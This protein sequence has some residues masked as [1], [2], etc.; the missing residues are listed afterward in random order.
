MTFFPRGLGWT[1]AAM[2]LPVVVMFAQHTTKKKS[3]PPPPPVATHDPEE[4]WACRLGYKV[5]YGADAHECKCPMM[6]Q[7][8]QEAHIDR[9]KGITDEKAYQECMNSIPGACDIVQ[10]VDAKHP[11]H[12]CGRW[13]TKP[14]CRCHDG[15][16]CHGDEIVPHKPPVA[17]PENNQ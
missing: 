13:C 8:A 6:V 15:P 1:V 4:A 7:E 12:S 9:C 17:D 16:V 10:K 2:V 14:V 3:T 5:G 11:E